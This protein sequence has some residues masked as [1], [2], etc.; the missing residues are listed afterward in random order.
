MGNFCMLFL[1]FFSTIREN[2]T[3]LLDRFENQDIT[4]IVEMQSL[5]DTL[6]LALTLMR[7]ELPAVDS[8]TVTIVFFLFNYS[9][10]FNFQ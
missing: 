3:A 7:E 1:F 6:K 8:F 10:I 4:Y 9:L 5:L 2:M